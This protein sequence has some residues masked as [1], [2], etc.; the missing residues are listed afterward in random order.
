MKKI[1]GCIGIMVIGS[2][3]LVALGAIFTGMKVNDG[4]DGEQ[5]A[6]SSVA[7]TVKPVTPGGKPNGTPQVDGAENQRA[8]GASK[9]ILRI[10]G[11]RNLWP[12][13]VTL[14]ESV[15]MPIISEGK[16]IGSMKIAVGQRLDLIN[17]TS[18]KVEVGR[19]EGRVLVDVNVTDLVAQSHAAQD[20]KK[21]DAIAKKKNHEAMSAAK[22]KGIDKSFMQSSLDANWVTYIEQNDDPD[23]AYHFY[24]R[25]PSVKYTTK[26]NVKNIAEHIARS[27]VMQS[28]NKGGTATKAT[29]HVFQG[30]K[31]LVRGTYRE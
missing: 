23:L 10:A 31:V 14:K 15:E 17:V 30:D 1:F 25:L 26:E 7:A 8:K 21:A 20:K 22:Q 18:E 13:Q 24:V 27:Y 29:I 2:I 19:D 3:I 28:K 16:Q 6:S 9:E 11:N 12:K 5:G 4:V